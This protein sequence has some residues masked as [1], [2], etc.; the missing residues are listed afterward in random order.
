MRGRLYDPKQRRFISP[1]PFVSDPFDGQSHNR[2]A[3]VLNNP[4]NLI[5]P[6]GFDASV[7]TAVGASKGMTACCG[8]GRGKGV[9]KGGAAVGHG[10]KGAGPPGAASNTM[11]AQPPIPGN[12][13]GGGAKGVGGPGRTPSGNSTHGTGPGYTPG[14]GNG[15]G[16]GPGPGPGST[17][18]S[19][20]GYGPTRGGSPTGSTAPNAAPNGIQNPQLNWFGRLVQRNC[21][22]CTINPDT[23]DELE[24][25]LLVL[26]VVVPGVSAA[27]RG[28]GATKALPGAVRGAEATRGGRAATGFIDDVVVKSH[29]KVIG[30]GTVD[31]RA[32][33]EGIQSGKLGAR[34][35]F[36]NREGLLPKQGPGY[37]QEYVHP[38]PGLSGAG[39]QRIV[40]GRGGELYYTPDH[41]KTFIPLN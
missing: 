12:P 11:L 27:L 25:A 33:V 18:D 23:L 39:P 31:V 34:D 36:Q 16:N 2:Y 13:S 19:V 21:P 1:D 8:T 20:G 26:S 24:G 4:L 28:V 15:P 5:D 37:Y 38:T 22:S 10:G 40:G 41:Y 3:Y 29:G 32:T 6:S 9:G 7:P 14:S 35:V 17:S 30:R